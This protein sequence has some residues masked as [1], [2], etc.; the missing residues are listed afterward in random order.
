[1]SA[2]GIVPAT[3]VPSSLPYKL[4]LLGIVSPI[5]Q[6]LV[7]L[8]IRILLRLF[9][10]RKM[11]LTIRHHLPHV[12]DVI[13]LVLA[14]IFLR[15]LL[16]DGDDLAARVVADCFTTPIVFGPVKSCEREFG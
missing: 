7:T 9:L 4:S 14:R 16:Q 13:L 12:I 8:A 10:L 11:P 2:F 3:A 1:M 5:L 15:I 6:T